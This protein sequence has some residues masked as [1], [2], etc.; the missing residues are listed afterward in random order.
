M[1]LYV[2]RIKK[3]VREGAFV[4][5]LAK[6]CEGCTAALKSFG[7]SNVYYTTDGTELQNEL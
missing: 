4:N 1:T 6:P 7:I 5:G 3:E 2:S